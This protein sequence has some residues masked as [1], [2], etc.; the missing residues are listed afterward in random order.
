MQA[1]EDQESMDKMAL[2]GA[3][4]LYLNVINMFLYLLRLFGKKRD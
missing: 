2:I 1:V 4:Q 3:L